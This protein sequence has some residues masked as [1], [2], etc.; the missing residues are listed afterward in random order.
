MLKNR[1][2]YY[3]LCYTLSAFKTRIFNRHFIGNFHASVDNYRFQLIKPSIEKSFKDR[4]M[5]KINANKIIVST[6]CEIMLLIDFLI[7]FFWFKNDF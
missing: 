1:Q 6:C 3:T 7:T 4:L 5:M 2:R